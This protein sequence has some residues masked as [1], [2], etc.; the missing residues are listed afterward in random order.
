VTETA[1]RV[2]GGVETLDLWA[3]WFDKNGV[4]HGKVED[5]SDMHPSLAFQDPEGQRLRLMAEPRSAAG[6]DAHPWRGSPVPLEAAIFGLGGVTL[7]VRDFDAT[8]R[9]L[10][11]VLGFRVNAADAA[12]FEVGH[13]GPGARLRLLAS[14]TPGKQGAGGV[15]HVA[16]SVPDA[17]EQE[18]WEERL[19]GFGFGVSGLVD[20]FYFQSLYF[21][22]PG[23]I[24]FE[25]AT[26]GPGF[27]ADGEDLEHLGERLSLPPFLETRRAEI[28]RGLRPL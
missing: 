6:D 23:G 11:E 19:G 24:L 9:A 27:T 16:W 8:A 17:K 20:R 21:R 14:A 15:H 22:I 4:Q 18:A 2:A 3:A 7:T 1:L 28:E 5:A 25:I 26:E 13:G 10:T 12:L